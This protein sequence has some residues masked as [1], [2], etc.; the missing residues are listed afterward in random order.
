MRKPVKTVPAKASHSLKD[1]RENGMPFGDNPIRVPPIE[2]LAA[3]GNGYDAQLAYVL[4]VIS[5]WAYADEKALAGKLRYYGVRG[6][7]V[8]RMSVQNDALLVVST[9]FLILSE[10]GSVGVLAFRGTDPASLIMLLADAQVMQRPFRGGKVHA[11]FHANVEAL[12][13]DISDAIEAAREGFFIDESGTRVPL[14][15]PMT[16]LYVTGHSLGG[17][18][19]VLAASRLFGDGY[20]SWKPRSLIRGVYTF[21]Q[22]M[23]GDDAFTT[24]CNEEFG[25]QSFRHVYR[26]DVVPHLPPKSGLSY[27]H[28][29]SERRSYNLVEAWRAV[30]HASRRASLAQAFIEVIASA[31]EL[32]FVAN[33]RLGGYSIDEHM[34][35]NYLQVSR[36]SA[37][38][39]TAAAVPT[40]TSWIDRLIK[41]AMGLYGVAR[42]GAS[43]VTQF[44]ST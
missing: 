10:S 40:S 23:V 42:H 13:D 20:E 6:A 27:M 8:R 19:A 17:A 2:Q 25:K 32:R 30:S 12:W 24:L 36:H 28:F 34:P 9:A 43:A 41:P 38:P 11:G 35:E 3:K 15:S 4:S 26:D 14:K 7:R 1:K 33:R 18:M 31:I 22:P 5:T 21:G 39:S 44:V 16:T 29:G 37:D